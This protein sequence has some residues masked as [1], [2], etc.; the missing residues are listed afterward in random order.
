MSEIMRNGI[1]Y[2]CGVEGIYGGVYIKREYKSACI[3][4][5]GR[6]ATIRALALNINLQT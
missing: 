4:A 1:R 6:F 2:D 3:K 5:R